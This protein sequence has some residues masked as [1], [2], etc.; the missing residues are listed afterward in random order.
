M[1]ARGYLWLP[2][3]ILAL[4]AAL[5]FWVER[6]VQVA[7]SG[8]RTVAAD[9][10]GIM[11]NFDA[12]RTDA[13]GQPHYRLSAV[14]L[15]HYSG[16]RL[17]ELESPHFVQLDANAGN[18]SAA[19]REATISPSGD[20]VEL[21]GDVV[22]ERAAHAGQPAMTLRTAQLLVFPDQDLLRAPGPVT[23]DDGLQSLRAGAMEYNAELRVIRLS[24]RVHARYLSGKG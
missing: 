23:I 9:P 7:D 12:L 18:V 24:G 14:R 2:L 10:E 16:N 13:T 1:S 15:K 11:E 17:T 4:L 19:S 8:G 22:V 21:R 3:A 20:E 6:A 5:S